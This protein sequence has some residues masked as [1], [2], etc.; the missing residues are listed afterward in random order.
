MNSNRARFALYVVLAAFLLT[1]AGR[2]L[3]TQEE[4]KLW[5]S[6]ASDLLGAGALALAAANVP[7]VGRGG[8]HRKAD[9]A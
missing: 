8:R 2:G 3:I 1:L 6:V 7:G 9:D 5:T 4:A